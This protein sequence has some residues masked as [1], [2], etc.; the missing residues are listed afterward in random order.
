MKTYIKFLINLFTISFFKVFLVFFA[1]IVITN[2]LEQVEFF[3]EIDYSFLS[4][5]FLSFLNSPSITFEIL[6]FIFLISTQIFFIKLI[7]K[8][9]LEIF[10]YV[11][12][13]NIKIIKIISIYSFILGLLFVIIFY[14][15]SSILK[16]SYLVIKNKYADDGKY[17]AVINENG[18]WIKDEIN[19]KINIINAN[20]VD[21]VFLLDVLITQFDINFNI[22]RTIQSERINISSLSWQVANPRILENNL[23]TI[24][25]EMRLASNFD[26]KKINSLFSNLSSLSIMDLIKLRKSYKSLNYSIIEIDAHLYKVITYPIYLTLITIFSSIIMFNIRYQSNSLFKIIYGIFF[27]VIIYYIN[28][29]F[30]VLGVSEKIPLI[31]SIV[32]PLVILSIINIISIIKLNE[33]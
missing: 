14:N 25:K 2:I 22:I 28:Y 31:L 9:E 6:P 3:N 13:N 8:N 29:F 10:K 30:N 11:G 5:A 23:M 26:L 12:L 32:F 4:I 24:S 21:D 1:I 18:L 27:S 16:N 19:Q 33:K 20:M 17:L 7:D 15:I